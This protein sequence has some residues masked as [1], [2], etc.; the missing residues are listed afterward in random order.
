M[1]HG[2]PKTHTHLLTGD[3]FVLDDSVLNFYPDFG[4]APA[5]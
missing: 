1:H 2:E 4:E 3:V 5:R